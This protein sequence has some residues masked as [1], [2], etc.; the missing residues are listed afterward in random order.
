[1][2]ID[3]DQDGAF[4]VFEKVDDVAVFLQAVLQSVTDGHIVMD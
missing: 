3:F 1:M 4:F 2:L